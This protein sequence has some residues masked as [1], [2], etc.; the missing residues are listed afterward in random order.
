MSGQTLERR[1]ASQTSGGVADE[2]PHPL[3]PML[4]DIQHL[5]LHELH[6]RLAEEGYAAI[7]PG[8]GCVFRFI[9][10]RGARLTELASRSG[11]SKQAV[12]EVVVDLEDLGYVERAPDPIDGRAKIIRLTESGEQ[13]QRTARRI[14][15]EIEAGWAERYGE[16]RIA[17][18]R[19]LLEEMT[20][21]L[22]TDP[23]RAAGPAT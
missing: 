7:R 18:L 2:F 17:A 16:Q 8:H 12:S 13:A 9:D 14:F 21:D 10:E 4:E 23:H 20:A 19:E 5:M 1:E 3:A 11:T 6:A 15:S 22:A